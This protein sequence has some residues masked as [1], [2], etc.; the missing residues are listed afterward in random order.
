MGFIV[1][2]PPV[3]N[4][5]TSDIIQINSDKW[6]VIEL[7]VQDVDSNMCPTSWS[8]PAYTLKATWMMG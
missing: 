5:D 1:Y 3:G 4:T 8:R 7:T 2:H 6:T